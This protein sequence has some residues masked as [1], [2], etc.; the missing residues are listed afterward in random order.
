MIRLHRLARRL[1]ALILLGAIAA[2]PASATM[3]TP[4]GTVPGLVVD[5]FDQGLFDLPAP[6][7]P[8]QT[9]SQRNEWLIPIIR[10]QYPDSSL[11]FGASALASL[12]FDTTGAN[13]HGSLSEYWRTVSRGRL[14]VRGEVVATVTVPRDRNYY[15]NDSWGVSAIS[16]PNN[17]AGLMKD[18]VFLADP[19]VDWR[20]FDLDGDG[21]VDMLWLVHPSR[22]AEISGSRR[23]LWSITSSMSGGWSN[24]AAIETQDLIPGSTTQR[25]RID[26]FSTLPERSG[27][28]S[29]AMSE[30]GVYCHEFGH[31]LGLPDLY[32]TSTLGGAANV[33]PGNWSLM[34]TGTYG[35]DNASPSS[36][37]HIGGW[38]QRYLGWAEWLHPSVDT[39]LTL[40]PLGAGGGVVS[41]SFEGGSSSEHFVLE[42]RHPSGIDRTLPSPGL[43]VTQVDEALIGLRISS[44]RVNTGP[45]PALRIIEGDADS[46]LFRGF[47]RGDSSDPFPGLLGITRLDDDTSPAL[48][49]L[50]GAATELAIEGITQLAD[51]I[52]ARV[53][54]LPRDWQPAVV[55]PV[56]APVPSFGPARRFRVRGEGTQV[57]VQ[58][59]VTASGAQVVVHERRRDRAWSEPVTISSSTAGAYEPTVALLPGDDLAVAWSDVAGGLAQI[60]YRARIRGVWGTER[61]ITQ[62][63]EG[64]SSPAIAADESGRISLAWLDLVLGAP[65]V[66]MLTFLYTAPFGTPYSLTGTGDL[67]TAPAVALSRTGE[68]AVAWADRSSGRDILWFARHVP[69]SGMAPRLRLGPNTADSQPTVSIE[70]DSAGALHS[71]WQ[72]SSEGPSQLHYQQRSRIGLPSPRDTII[73]GSGDAVQSPKLTVDLRH[74]VHVVYERSTLAGSE[75]RYLRWRPGSGWDQF[76]TRASELGDH[77]ATRP[78]VGAITHGGV[79]VAYTDFV[80]S[81]ETVRVRSRRLSGEGVLDAPDSGPPPM[82]ATGLTLHPHPLRSGQVLEARGTGLTLGIRVELIDAG[83]RRVAETRVRHAGAARF[84]AAQT[85]GLAPGMYFVR[86]AGTDVSQRVVVL[87]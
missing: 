13:P 14:R 83:G 2:M 78:E 59:Q 33:G 8:L 62:A 81:T 10:V 64:A 79:D 40:G 42:C 35:G 20:R 19:L 29:G 48:R 36:P 58:A 57:L 24:S 51:S 54:V 37:T 52:R 1:S 18:A 74:G 63:P 38:A 76:P 3:P 86:Y 21:F 11:A 65:R 56:Q 77:L 30:I 69:D 53:R 17:I 5:G 9:S 28:V 55:T 22:G 73:E 39:T 27:Y 34:S 25:I 68:T 4:A 44:N 80:G 61:P 7:G 15:A 82:R 67:P 60:R 85:Q 47:N 31:A 26:R 84:A 43:I 70:Y 23:D 16:T 71:V 87:R 75:I 6:L 12:L 46:D 66:R 49:S 32:D 72:T 45:S 41:Q 50:A